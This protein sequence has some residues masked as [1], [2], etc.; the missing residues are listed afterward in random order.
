MKWILLAIMALNFG[1]VNNSLEHKF[2]VSNTIVEFNRNLGNFEVTC[3]IFTDD[4]E[5]GLTGHTGQKVGLGG[6]RDSHLD[7]IMDDYIKK[8]LKITF[9]DKPVMLSYVG[10]ESEVD[11]TYVYFEIIAE[12]DFNVMVVENSLLFEVYPEQK[13]IVDVR[14]DGWTK[15]SILTKENPREI[16]FR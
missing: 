14:K 7:F 11:L 5:L 12:S 1:S 2:Y 3:K 13:N 16:I 10:Y 8:H 9:N 4:L 15:T 6:N